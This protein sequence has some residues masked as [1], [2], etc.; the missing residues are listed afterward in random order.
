M[1]TDRKITRRFFRQEEAGNGDSESIS[2]SLLGGS[3][4]VP[5]VRQQL[6]PTDSFENGVVVVDGTSIS[7][8]PLTTE[9]SRLV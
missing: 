4:T 9:L 1:F 5:Q 8:S 6:H 3:L 2:S 7:V